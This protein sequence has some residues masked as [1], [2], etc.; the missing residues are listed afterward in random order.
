MAAA[1]V[2]ICSFASSSAMISFRT[3]SS[4]TKGA[5]TWTLGWGF[6][7]FGSPLGKIGI[8]WPDAPK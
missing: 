1:A 8:L 4:L 7:I 3:C 2:G 6:S 5:S